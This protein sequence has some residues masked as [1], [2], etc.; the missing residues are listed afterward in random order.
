M[1]TTSNKRRKYS[2][3]FKEKALDLLKT[4]GLPVSQVAKSLGIE[5]QSLYNW[6]RV[7]ENKINTDSINDTD[8][9]KR[10][11]EALKELELV[12]KE[13]EILVK[14]TAFFAKRSD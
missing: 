5:A 7:S 10:L 6:R 13:N 3:E 8:I 14:A 1:N 9:K 11:E 12:K 2:K 4:S